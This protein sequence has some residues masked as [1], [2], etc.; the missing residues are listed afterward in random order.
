MRRFIFSLPVF[1]CSWFTLLISHTFSFHPLLISTPR[2]QPSARSIRSS[3]SHVLVSPSSFSTSY[4]GITSACLR[5]ALEKDADSS[6]DD[7]EEEEDPLSKGIDSVSWLPSVKEKQPK[8]K[9][10]KVSKAL[11]TY[12]YLIPSFS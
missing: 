10:S 1:F 11:Y 6:N 7:D 8:E 5:M 3:P 12:R 9:D 4:R 2:L